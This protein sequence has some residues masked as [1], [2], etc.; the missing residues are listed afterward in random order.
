MRVVVIPPH[1]EEVKGREALTILII[2]REIQM[3][4]NNN[5]EEP[6]EK[7]K[8]LAKIEKK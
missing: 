1:V 8:N 6:L 5:K 7:F 2:A 3:A 4:R